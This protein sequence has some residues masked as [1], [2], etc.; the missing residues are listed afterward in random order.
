MRSGRFCIGD[1]VRA[2]PDGVPGLVVDLGFLSDTETPAVV[3]A[4]ASGPDGIPFE[5]PFPA[6]AIE[7]VE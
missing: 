3:V 4:W 2:I 7:L 1:K 6:D 5:Y